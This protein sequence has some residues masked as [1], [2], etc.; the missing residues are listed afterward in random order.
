MTDWLPTY[1]TNVHAGRD[2]A[3]TEATRYFASNARLRISV[4]RK[5]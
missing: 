4:G 3:E 5:A 2:L 1:C